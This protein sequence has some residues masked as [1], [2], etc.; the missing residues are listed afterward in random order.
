[1]CHVRSTFPIAAPTVIISP[2]G[3]IEAKS[4]GGV[5]L[6]MIFHSGY[7]SG[8]RCQEP[9]KCAPC[10]LH[11]A[12]I[13]RTGTRTGRPTSCTLAAM[14]GMTVFFEGMKQR[15][16]NET[17]RMRGCPILTRT[18]VMPLLEGVKAPMYQNPLDPPS[19]RFRSLAV[20]CQVTWICF[21]GMHVG[22]AVCPK[23]ARLVGLQL[24]TLGP[25]FHCESQFSTCSCAGS[26]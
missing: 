11:R 21:F 17:Y 19:V 13:C 10:F 18:H 12:E 6:L 2:V 22:S 20:I 1:M 4:Q 8:G 25:Q 14:A 3:R 16:Q 23:S 7:I 24:E 5:W 15:N 9:L 26:L